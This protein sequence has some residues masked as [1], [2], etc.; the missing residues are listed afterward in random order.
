MEYYSTAE[1]KIKLYITPHEDFQ[2][3]WVK[4][5]SHRAIPYVKPFRLKKMGKKHINLLR[6]TTLDDRKQGC[7]EVLSLFI[8]FTL[9]LL[10]VFK[11]Y[12]NE[13][14]C[15]LKINFKNIT[16]VSFLSHSLLIMFS[17]RIW[18]ERKQ[19]GF[20]DFR[21]SHLGSSVWLW[22][23]SCPLTESLILGMPLWL[24]TAFYFAWIFEPMVSGNNY[25]SIIFV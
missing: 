13:L 7:E 24:E 12:F 16:V 20:I 9:I 6:V 5:A 14:L 23:P 21:I 1:N 18:T 2:H 17:S 25:V 10:T 19:S 22:F 4:I 3:V 11:V 15:S 8:P